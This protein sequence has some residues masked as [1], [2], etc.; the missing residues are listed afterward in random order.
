MAFLLDRNPYA[1]V[2][3]LAACCAVVRCDAVLFAA[4]LVLSAVVLRRVKFWTAAAVAV[5]AAACAIGP[6]AAPLGGGAV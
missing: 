1:G 6:H 3:L 4:P 5:A 2:A